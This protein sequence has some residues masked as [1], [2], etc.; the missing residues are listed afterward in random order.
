[1]FADKYVASSWIKNKSVL[2]P[3]LSEM[4]LIQEK[5]GL[6]ILKIGMNYSC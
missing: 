3:K 1:M 2:K 5:S 4:F 6:S